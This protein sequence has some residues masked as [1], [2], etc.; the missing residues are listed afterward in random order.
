MHSECTSVPCQRI[1]IVDEGNDEGA[2]MNAPCAGWLSRRVT[3]LRTRRHNLV[4][5]DIEN[6]T[7]GH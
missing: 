6:P 3:T 1:A 7:P 2:F 4:R 5:S